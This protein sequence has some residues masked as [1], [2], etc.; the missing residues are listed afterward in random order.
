MPYPL[1]IQNFLFSP[2]KLSI[3][4]QKKRHYCEKISCDTHS[5]VNFPS[6]TVLKKL[7]F[8]WKSP[9]FSLK[10]PNFVRF[11][12]SYYFSRILLQIFY[13]L[14]IKKCSRSEPSNIGHLHIG[15]YQLASNAKNVSLE[16]TVF[17]PYLIMGG[18]W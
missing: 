2:K 17:L 11:E 15:H 16:W 6:L 8:F 3:Q 18:K 4:V 9:L 12:N 1:Q 14:L 13:N 7:K 5:I 10:K